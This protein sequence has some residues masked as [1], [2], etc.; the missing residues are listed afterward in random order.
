VRH[1]TGT[2]GIG[3]ANDVGIIELP[4]GARNIPLAVFVTESPRTPEQ[5]ERAIAP[6]ARSAYDYFLFS[7]RTAQ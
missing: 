5:Q 2:P 1:K 4:A 7:P 6:I 3:V